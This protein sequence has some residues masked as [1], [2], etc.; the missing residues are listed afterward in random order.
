MKKI[1]FGITNLDIGG[2]EKSLVDIVNN[3]VIDYDIT[4]FTIY[5]NGELESGLTDKVKV[6]NFQ[7]N[8]FKNTSKIRKKIIG[9]MFL[10]NF[11]LKKIYK[12]YINNQFDIE[13]AFLEGSITN[14]FSIKSNAK[15]LVW[16]HTDLYKHLKKQYWKYI[17]KY[18][19]YD[20]IIFVSEEIIKGFNKTTNNKVSK[21]VI[22]NFI[23]KKRI[24]KDSD[25]FNID[26]DIDYLVIA[27]LAEPKGLSRLI[28]VVNKLKMNN[29]DI[30]IHVVGGG[31]EKSHLEKQIN[32]YNLHNNIILLGP[33]ENPYPYLKK[34]KILLIPSLYEGYPLV[35]IE[36]M[37]FS[38]RIISTNTG[39]KEVLKD[40]TNKIIVDNSFEGLY[41]GLRKEL[42]T[43]KI[44]ISKDSPSIDTQVNLEEIKKE[45]KN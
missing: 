34:S 33:K 22:H 2:A 45:L 24:L 25:E 32:N 29:M 21:K 12:K 11:C 23:D 15:K 16:V 20:K 26:F 13:I 31:D 9:A 3:L 10:S 1:V 38:K 36:G 44:Q 19:S 17:S 4:I 40:Y 14:L 35:A 37:I 39:A 27:R 5:G 42:T 43:H 28:E 18:N 30:K 41:K 6:I 8:S 7:K